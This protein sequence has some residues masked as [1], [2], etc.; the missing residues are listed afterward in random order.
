[1]FSKFLRGQ[2]PTTLAALKMQWDMEFAKANRKFQKSKIRK[3]K[4]KAASR[5]AKSKFPAKWW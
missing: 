1:M 4:G 3:K 5:A 2:D